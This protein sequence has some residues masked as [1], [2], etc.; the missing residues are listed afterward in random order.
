[1]PSGCYQTEYLAF[2]EGGVAYRLRQ[3]K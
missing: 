2:P 1:M 3:E